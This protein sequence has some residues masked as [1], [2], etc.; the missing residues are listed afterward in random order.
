M[1]SPHMGADHPAILIVDDEVP[2]AAIIGA[3]VEDLGY[4]AHLAAQGQQALD[5][6]RAAWPALVITDL[7]MPVLSGADLIAALRVETTTQGRAYVP[8]I[9]MTAAQRAC[10]QG[11]RRC[12]APQTL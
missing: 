3:V 9:L 12:G 4:R 8:V 6:A 10:T 11:G 1:T 5:L 7:M 2:I